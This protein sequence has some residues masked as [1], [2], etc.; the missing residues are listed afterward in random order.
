MRVR[1]PTP[2]VHVVRMCSV[3]SFVARGMRG[4]WPLYVGVD[5]G[6]GDEVR[7]PHRGN[8]LVVDVR[9]RGSGAHGKK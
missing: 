7:H 8:V 5:A 6:G 9:N 3:F 2:F 4:N 1:G